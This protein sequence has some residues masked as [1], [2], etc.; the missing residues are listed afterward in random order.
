MKDRESSLNRYHENTGGLLDLQ[1]IGA[2]RLKE[3]N[4]LKIRGVY[5]PAPKSDAQPSQT[6]NVM[7]KIGLYK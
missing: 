4:T 2:G 5:E 7:N 6:G 3:Y 1:N